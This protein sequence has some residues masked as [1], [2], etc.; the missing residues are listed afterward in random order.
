MIYSPLQKS[1]FFTKIFSLSIIFQSLILVGCRSQRETLSGAAHTETI[2][3]RLH[4]QMN[5]TL[6]LPAG[7]ISPFLTLDTSTISLASAKRSEHAP[8]VPVAVRH[9][10]LSISDTTSTQ[11]RDSVQLISST[12]RPTTTATQSSSLPWYFRAAKRLVVV[13]FLCFLL[14][15]LRFLIKS[16]KL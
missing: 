1:K 2:F 5:D 13:A 9:A 11:S 15:G 7:K 6:F 4:A 16:Q 14:F 10:N 3:T 12:Y 8:L